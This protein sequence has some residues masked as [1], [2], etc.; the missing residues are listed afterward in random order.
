[1]LGFG[2]KKKGGPFFAT[3]VVL[4]GAIGVAV[5]IG[6]MAVQIGESTNTAGPTAGGL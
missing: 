3:G 6:G 4:L 2:K 5:G 1:M